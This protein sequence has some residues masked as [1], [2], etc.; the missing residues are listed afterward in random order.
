[1]LKSLWKAINSELNNSEMDFGFQASVRTFGTNQ[2]AYV[3]IMTTEQ[4]NSRFE[5]ARSPVGTDSVVP[6]LGSDPPTYHCPEVEK[7]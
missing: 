2:G 6:K 3:C 1:M 7:L 5:Q 4:T